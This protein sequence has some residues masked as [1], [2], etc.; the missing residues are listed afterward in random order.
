[1]RRL[2]TLRRPRGRS[3]SR[4]G[5][6]LVAAA[7]VAGLGATSPAVPPAHADVQCWSYD[8]SATGATHQKSGTPTMY[9]NDGSGPKLGLGLNTC[10]N[11][12]AVTWSA[13]CSF[14]GCSPGT[15]YEI[16]WWRPGLDGWKRLTLTSSDAQYRYP[17]LTYRF[18][19]A[20]RDTYYGFAA[21]KCDNSGCRAWSPTVSIST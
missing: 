6:I 8:T 4:L 7:L 13:L 9:W 11:Y 14:E 5:V 20:L 17:Y 10:E 3:R 19:N 1:M 2:V 18:S 12:I 16:D 15:Y 21:T